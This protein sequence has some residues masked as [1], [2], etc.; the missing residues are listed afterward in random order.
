[1]PHEQTQGMNL[2]MVTAILKVTF[3]VH[4]VIDVDL[5]WNIRLGI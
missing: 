2:E 3:C 5:Q 1:M 4:V